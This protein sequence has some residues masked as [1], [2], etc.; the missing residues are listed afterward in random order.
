MVDLGVD[1]TEAKKVA[2]G[3]FVLENLDP[4]RDKQIYLQN[5]QKA[6]DNPTVDNLKA[7]GFD[8]ASDL[9]KL[10]EDGSK[11]FDEGRI[12]PITQRGIVGGYNQSLVDLTDMGKGLSTQRTYGY[13]TPDK[14]ASYLDKSYGQLF[15]EIETAKLAQII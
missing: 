2:V 9:T 15:K 10:V 4:K 7:I 1:P 3:Q 13:A 6:I 8:K 14:V 5:V 12:F 11:A